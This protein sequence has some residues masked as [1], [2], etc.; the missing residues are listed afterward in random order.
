MPRALISVSDKRGIIAFAQGLVELG[1]ELIST[2]GTAAALRAGRRAG[3]SRSIRSPASP[4]CSTAGSRRCTRRCTA[5]CSPGATARSTWRALEAS[6]A[7]RRSTC[8]AVNLYPFRADHR[9]A[10]RHLRGRDREHRYRR[11]V[12]APLGGEEL[13]V[14]PRPSSTRRDYADGARAAPRRA[15]D[16]AR[17]AARAGGQGLR[18]TPPT[19]TAPS[20]RY[21]T[22]SE[23]GLPAPH[24]ASRWS[25]AGAALRREP[26]AARR[27]LRRPRSR[28]ACAT[29]KQRQGKE[30]SFN[31]L[32]D[33]DAAMWAVA[34]WPTRPAC[35]I[36]KHTTPCGIAIGATGR[37]RRSRA[38]WPRDPQ[39]AFGGVVAFNTVVD[40][41]TAE[42]MAD[43]FLEVVVAPVVP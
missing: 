1:W 17:D 5:A 11:T 26:A 12:D 36:V 33:L 21:L 41:A 42:A 22:P 13:R 37:S 27:A 23:E 4:R 18:A 43:L 2:G 31:N 25:G 28:A 34:P 20:P 39:S 32:L 15:S 8:V 10:G 9:Q 29:S 16:P 40:K 19:T 35:A 6:T 30:L 24:R 3:A 7:S 14:R 38:H